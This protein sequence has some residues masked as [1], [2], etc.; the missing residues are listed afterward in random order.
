MKKLIIFENLKIMK[1]R[2]FW[3][4][5]L[6]M[7]ILMIGIC[8]LSVSE[9]YWVKDDGT[10]IKGWNAIN[11]KRE[12]LI[13]LSGDLT[14]ESV[15]EIITQY[16]D[17]RNNQSNY[18]KEDGSLSSEFNN[19]AY[20]KYLQKD[21]DILNLLRELYAPA[22]ENYDYYI[23]DSIEIEELY[24]LYDQRIKKVEEYLNMDYSYGNYTEEEKE[25]FI[26]LNR[27][28]K[29]PFYYS[30]YTA[31]SQLLGNSY[32]MIMIIVMVISISLSPVFASEYQSGADSVLLST[33]YGR[34]K[35]IRA[36]FCSAFMITSF[37]YIFGMGTY[38][39]LNIII[40]GTDG[41]NCSL[42]MSNLLAPIN[43]NMLQVYMYVIITGYLLC[44][45]MQG[46]VLLL[47]SRMK[48]PFSVIICSL[49]LYFIPFFIP[50]SK[51]S[52]LF[53]NILNLFPAKMSAAYAALGKYEVY[54]IL[55]MDILYSTMIVLT[56]LFFIIITVPL[57]SKAFKNHQVI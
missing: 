46:I 24:K 17:A 16:Q 32:F 15:V 18:I 10:E 8:A 33:K 3:I 2:S 42:Q 4:S 40:Y 7:I 21:A 27:N 30:N 25:Y 6:L 52:R 43:A 35:L 29:T 55:G 39:L 36:K 56:C 14:E 41:W 23:I 13:D 45:S 22:G 20:A 9:N 37:I 51:E 26:D 47:S 57:A 49:L 54:H 19:V 50:Y 1:R 31:W 5:F 48:T 11:F 44:I 34:S 38:T 28:I 53:N 12:K